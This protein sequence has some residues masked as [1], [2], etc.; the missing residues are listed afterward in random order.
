MEVQI[1]EQ[2]FRF[3]HDEVILD[4][5]GPR[6]QY[7]GSY[8]EEFRKRA[9][10]DVGR[11]I[12]AFRKSFAETFANPGPI[13]DF[14]CGYAAIVCED[15]SD[16]WRGYDVMKPTIEKLGDKYASDVWKFDT[17]CMFDVLEHLADPVAFLSKARPGTR[18]IVTV[19]CW[20]RWD[21]LERLADWKHFKPGEHLLYA[22]ARGLV[23]ML[24]S[25]A[26]YKLLDHNCFEDTFGREDS[27]TFVFERCSMSPMTAAGA[28]NND[29]M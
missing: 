16:R 25:L 11:R 10:S 23:G 3:I 15:E 2:T 26:G 21:E 5:L 6:E 7:N 4:P 14:G 24:R 12:Y 20:D 22:S 1:G 18:L 28:L 8:F 17:I 27:H 9:E 13:L 29:A 19:P